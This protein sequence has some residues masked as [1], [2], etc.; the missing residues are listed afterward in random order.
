MYLEIMGKI[1][2]INPLR[3][4]YY[5]GHPYLREEIKRK[6]IQIEKNQFDSS[7]KPKGIYVYNEKRQPDYSW[8]P[9]FFFD[10]YD[11]EFAESYDN[12]ALRMYDYWQIDTSKIKNNWFKDNWF[13]RDFDVFKGDDRNYNYIYTDTDIP[14]SAIKLFRFQQEKFYFSKGEKGSVH[15]RNIGEFRP[16]NENES[17]L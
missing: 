8:Y 13:R 16:F 10:F 14:A 17:F 12:D 4:V 1:K 11:Y 7:K 9:F 2:K 15:M 5:V 6:G 3:F